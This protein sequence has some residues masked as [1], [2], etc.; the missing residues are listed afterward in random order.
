MIMK[1]IK[2][3]NGMNGRNKQE[4]AK[5]AST[6]TQEARQL[7][8][9]PTSLPHNNTVHSQRVPP[10]PAGLERRK[11]SLTGDSEERKL[12]TA[13]S[14]AAAAYCTCNAVTLAG[15]RPQEGVLHSR[16]SRPV[17]A[18]GP[19][20]GAT[21]GESRRVSTGRGAPRSTSEG[22]QKRES[23]QWDGSLRR[24][25]PT[26]TKELQIRAHDTQGGRGPVLSRAREPKGG[27]Q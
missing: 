18:E 24:V 20:Q 27:A 25:L 10:V 26:L 11:T 12:T 2:K 1:K 15:R 21:I 14:M 22:T 5:Q 16:D 17:K 8:L 6:A 7:K 13:L 3:A 23:G 4:T 9:K 19:G